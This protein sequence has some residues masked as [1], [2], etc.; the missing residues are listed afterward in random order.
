[1]VLHKSMDPESYMKIKLCGFTDP[2]S[3]KFALK[4]CPD[5]MGFVFYPPSK[6][7][8]TLNQAKR[9]SKIDF[10]QT[11]KIAVIV[12]ENDGNISKIID[13][14][15]P[16]L[17]QL[18]GNESVS[19]CREIKDKFSLPIIKAIAISN[20]EDVSHFVEISQNYNQTADFLLFDTKSQER[21]G[22]GLS[23]DWR[24]LEQLN[25][26]QN[27]FLSGGIDIDNFK[28]AAETTGANFFDLSSGIEEI[29]GLK[30][31]DKIKNLM[32]FF[33]EYQQAKPFGS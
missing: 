4:Y 24:I 17:L 21:G 32:N 19:R 5:F 16:D 27:F 29:K 2:I 12:D 15:R 14:L 1:L 25:L 22:S 30:S 11:K 6:R 10:G 28:E 31:L 23:F 26:K 13:S 7:N 18:H 20:E 8:I 3:I 9:F 33:H